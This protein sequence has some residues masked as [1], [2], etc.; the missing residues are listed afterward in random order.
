MDIDYIFKILVIGS[1]NVGKSCFVNRFIDDTFEE[2]Y[3]STVGMEYGSTNLNLGNLKIKVELWDT[4][5]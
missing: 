4:A 5:G 3:K 2:N 1:S